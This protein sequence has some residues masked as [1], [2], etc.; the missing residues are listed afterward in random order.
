MMGGGDLK[1]AEYQGREVE[2]L[3]RAPL[4]GSLALMGNDNE[5]I[6]LQLDRA[7]AEALMATLT[8]FLLKGEGEDAPSPPNSP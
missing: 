3:S 7:S 4:V 2:V 6:D 8:V 1:T 5:P